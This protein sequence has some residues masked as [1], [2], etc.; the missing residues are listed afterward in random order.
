M[1][2]RTAAASAVI[3]SQLGREA[4]A[5]ALF[6]QA[7]GRGLDPSGRAYWSA[8]LLTTSRPEVLAQL[9]GS[10]EYFRRAGSTN[11]G[12][13]TAAYQTVLGRGT[14]AAGKAYW[15]SKLNAGMSRA[16]FARTLVASTEFRR[17]TVDAAYQLVLG[18]APDAA[19]RS[20][21]TTKLATTRVEVLLIQLASSS[22]Y[23]LAEM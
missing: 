10:A 14:D 22:A 23:Y 21:W 11:A 3:W 6:Q 16:Q 12:F 20:Y 7:F 9:V 5:N 13:V 4:A 19:G 18:R 8:K 15:V 1:A 2:A 17:R